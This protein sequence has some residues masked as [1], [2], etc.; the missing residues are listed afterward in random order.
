MEADGASQDQLAFLAEYFANAG[1]SHNAGRFYLRAGHYRAVGKLEN[2]F[3]GF[4]PKKVT[5][6]AL[7]YLMACGE[8]HE[9]LIL[10]IEAVAAA[11]D[12]KLTARLTDFLMGEVDGIPKVG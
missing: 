6:K 3:F 12:N 10:A 4:F 7:E 11:G 5:L 2:L 8:N 1:D 9:S